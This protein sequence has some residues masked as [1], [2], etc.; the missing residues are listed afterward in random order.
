MDMPMDSIWLSENG[1]DSAIQNDGLPEKG[2]PQ[3]HKQ[4]AR[5]SRRLA[6][7]KAPTNWRTWIPSP[8]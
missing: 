7:D 4:R 3:S 6:Q 2:I 5:Q 8:D 1:G